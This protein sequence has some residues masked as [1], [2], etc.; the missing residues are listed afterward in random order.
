ML[1]RSSFLSFFIFNLF[2]EDDDD[3]DSDRDEG[4]YCVTGRSER[5]RFTS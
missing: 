2:G 4:E 1:F 3:D 5:I